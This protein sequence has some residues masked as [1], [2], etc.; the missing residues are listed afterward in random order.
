MAAHPKPG[1]AL[2]LYGST[3][4]VEADTRDEVIEILKNDIYAR[5]GVWNVDIAQILPVSPS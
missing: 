4:T 1:E 2:Q 5:S 3:I